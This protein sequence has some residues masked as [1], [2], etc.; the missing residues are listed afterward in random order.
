MHIEW[1]ATVIRILLFP[2]R[3]V[4]LLDHKLWWW[5][6]ELL[7]SN[8]RSALSS[9]CI[10]SSKSWLNT[11][12]IRKEKEQMQTSWW[13][14]HNRMWCN[15]FHV[16]AGDTEEGALISCGSLFHCIVPLLRDS[17]AII[18][19]GS[20]DWDRCKHRI[21]PSTD[22]HHPTSSC[23]H[24]NSLC[25]SFYWCDSLM[26][27]CV[28]DKQKRHIQLRICTRKHSTTNPGKWNPAGYQ[29]VNT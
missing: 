9:V 2:A 10:N 8:I 26:T 23:Q 19:F 3:F 24:Q 5:N 15:T 17:H 25:R 29:Q 4:L 13:N 21:L 16:E 14:E 20:P 6:N 1:C 28:S 18:T 12:N 22:G 11:D 7:S 27:E